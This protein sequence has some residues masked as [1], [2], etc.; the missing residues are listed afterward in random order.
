MASH[1]HRASAGADSFTAKRLRL[2]AQGCRF[3]Y[4][5]LPERGQPNR[6]AVAA[7]VATRSGLMTS[8]QS[9]SQG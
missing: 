7:I 8:P 1:S 2:R 6:N 5:G 3:G 4:L 9:S